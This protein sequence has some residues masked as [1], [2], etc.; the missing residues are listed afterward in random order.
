[1]STHQT[2]ACRLYRHD[3]LAREGQRQ[4]FLYRVLDGWACAYRSLPEGRRQIT[5][6]YLPG[7]FCDP[8]WVLRATAHQP[9]LALT[10]MKLARVRLSEVRNQ[11]EGA[12]APQVPGMATVTKAVLQQLDR[13]T[14]WI[15]GLGRRTGLERVSAFICEL[16][17]RL[18]V[19]AKFP[20]KGFSVPL[21]QIDLA[22]IVGMTP[23]H[24]NRILKTLRSEGLVE[25]KEKW[26]RVP[27]M[28]G[29]RALAS[30][31]V[32]AEDGLSLPPTA[33]VP[34]QSRREGNLQ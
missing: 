24:V 23:I 6:L 14:D 2:I 16:A 29:L 15:V 8:Q 3:H 7:E 28:A 17:D 26:V 19:A 1:M 22:D 25:W 13:Q 5:A 32:A 30:G 18:G 31:S 33:H 27:D 4:D 11:P 21:T 34:E 20:D 12:R 10:D 9:V